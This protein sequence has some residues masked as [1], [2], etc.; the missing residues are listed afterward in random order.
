MTLQD[1]FLYFADPQNCI[2]YMVNLRWP[3]GKV[4]CPNCGSNAVTWMPTRNLFQCK[5]R[6]PK[7][8]F[9]VKVGTIYEDSPIALGKWLL[10]AWMLGTCRNGISSY[11]VART[12]GITQKSAWFMLHRLREAMKMEGVVLSGEVE[13]DECYIGGHPRNKHV[14]LR[15]QRKYKN[16]APVFGMVQRGGLAKAQAIP[17]V[18]GKVIHPMLTANM[19]PGTTLYTDSASTY[20]KIPAGFNHHRISHIDDKFVSGSVSTNSIEN[21]WAC[22]KRTLK[23]TYISV[24]PQ[25]LN[26][27]VEEQVFRFNHRFKFIPEERRLATMLEGAVGKRLTYKQL[28]AR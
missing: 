14:K 13:A 19:E 6:H 16:K 12:I 8:Q 5:G 11:E 28:T 15:A 10:I 7:R 20:D 23:G 21:L 25:H 3:D 27:Y 17:A 18:S 9:S 4:I 24:Q 1:A 26:S 22:L 2:D